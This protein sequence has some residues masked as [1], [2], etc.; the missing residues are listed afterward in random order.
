MKHTV[1]SGFLAASLALALTGS[2]SA[3][4]VCTEGVA[5][6]GECV[7]PPTI[8]A[9]RQDA[10][11]FSQPK[12]SYTAYPVLPTVDYLYRYPDQLNPNQLAPA[13]RGCKINTIC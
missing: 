10:L 11:I 5:A 6:N 3:Q 8:N 1:R 12:I 9:M 13:A 4:S 7:N 2:A